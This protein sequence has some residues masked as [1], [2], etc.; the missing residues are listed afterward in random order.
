MKRR[1]YLIQ[2]LSIF[3]VL[4]SSAQNQENLKLSLRQ[5]QDYA[6]EHNAAMKNAKLDIE[7]ARKKIWETTAI[8]LPQVSATGSYQ[9][10]F[11]VPEISFGGV[12]LLSKQREGYTL[13]AVPT[14]H[15][16]DSIFLNFF[17]GDPIKLGVA[18]N[19]NMNLSISQLV[20]SGEYLVGLQAT[21]VFYQISQNSLVQT[22]SDLKETVANSYYLVQILEK[23]RD[24]LLQSSCNLS[25]TLEEMKEMN[26]AG[27]IED[28]DVDQIELT[29]LSMENAVRSLDN[30]V[31]A[32]YDLLKFQMGIPFEDKVTLS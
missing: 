31:A 14:G 9:H 6:L 24:I 13:S 11:N 1:I 22:I 20:F 18:N 28:T 3:I 27:F 17:Q 26:K 32:S 29:L 4:T 30:Q 5:A 2:L 16:N 10:I 12:S 8:G 19:A 15:N 23:N 25:K 21:R 7:L